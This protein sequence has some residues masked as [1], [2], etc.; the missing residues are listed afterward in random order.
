[1][2][3]GTGYV[4]MEELEA[5]LREQG[6]TDFED[7]S[8]GDQSPDYKL[9]ARAMF[10]PSGF[11]GEALKLL[12][13][14]GACCA[15]CGATEDLTLDHIKSVGAYFNQIGYKQTKQQRSDWYN[16]TSNLQILCRSCNSSKG[17]DRFDMKKVAECCHHSRG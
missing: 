3:D 17:G 6:I 13:Q 10:F 4:G 1:M 9:S 7:E 16:D 8:D 14:D 12:E 5:Y 11:S 2:C 15:I